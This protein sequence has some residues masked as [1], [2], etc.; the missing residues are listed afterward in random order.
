MPKWK[1]ASKREEDSV[2]VRVKEQN[3]CIG[4]KI[5]QT[6]ESQSKGGRVPEWGAKRKQVQHTC[7]RTTRS[8]KGGNDRERRGNNRKRDEKKK[9]ISNNTCYG[10]NI[11]PSTMFIKMF[12]PRH[13]FMEVA[14]GL[15]TAQRKGGGWGEIKV[16]RRRLH[17]ARVC[18]RCNKV[19]FLRVGCRHTALD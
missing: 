6:S 14:D 17:W 19:R 2:W 3:Q 11:L 18:S 7:K 16:A 13:A 9:N 1:K 10:V 12:G 8:G 15:H 4:W 5:E